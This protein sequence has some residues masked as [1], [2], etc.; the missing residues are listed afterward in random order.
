MVGTASSW[1][2][3]FYE[4]TKAVIKR[5]GKNFNFT[6]DYPNRFIYPKEPVKCPK[7][8]QSFYLRPL[9][10][11]DPV[12]FGDINLWPCYKCGSTNTGPDGFSPKG[13]R[14]VMDIN[15]NYYLMCRQYKCNGCSSTFICS[16]DEARAMLP[17]HVQALFPCVL[18]EKGAID[19]KVWKLLFIFC[20]I[21]TL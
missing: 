2:T 3:K 19:V 11:W 18:Y 8:P 5:K 9:Y 15:E 4:E 7:G 17:S 14:E 1:Q 16:T 20:N 13:I 10:F 12:A 6:L 21:E